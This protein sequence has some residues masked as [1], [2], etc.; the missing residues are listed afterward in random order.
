M[1]KEKVTLFMELLQ[2]EEIVALYKHFSGA[3]RKFKDRQDAEMGLLNVAFGKL[4]PT[5][6]QALKAVGIDIATV[7]QFNQQFR[8]P[9][10]APDGYMKE[11]ELKKHQ[12][13]LAA[14]RKPGRPTDTT[15]RDA[16]ILVLLAVR[17]MVPADAV[18]TDESK[19]TNSTQIAEKLG[20]NINLVCKSLEK[21][22]KMKLL[23]IEDD[24]NL[25]H[26]LFWVKQV[27]PAGREMVVTA[28]LQKVKLAGS[29]PGPRC[30]FSGMRLYRL[31]A[32]NPR[33]AGTH[34]FTS[35]ALIKDG[36]TYEDYRKAG[37]RNN[38]LQWDIDKKFI[39]LRADGVAAP[40]VAVAEKATPVQPEKKTAKAAAKPAPKAAKKAVAKKAK[41]KHKEAK[42]K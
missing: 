19:L 33:R 1:A 17:E 25:E 30:S 5:I 38:D 13:A 6:I 28:P 39:E 2:M 29:N 8:G 36:M 16:D 7:N 10:I 4:R 15:L 26:Q 27:T 42:A 12:Q 37:G 20:T 11:K 9:I 41:T 18:E 40:P 14:D 34:G 22:T 23:E 3:T 35:F 24:S 32:G 31:V 21:L